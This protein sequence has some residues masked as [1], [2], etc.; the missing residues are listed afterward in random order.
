MK[1]FQRRSV[2]SL[3]HKRLTNFLLRRALRHFTVHVYHLFIHGNKIPVLVLFQVGG[4]I[5]INNVTIIKITNIYS[6]GDVEI[7]ISPSVLQSLKIKHNKTVRYYN[8]TGFFILYV[9]SFYNNIH[10]GMTI[11]EFNLCYDC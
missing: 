9:S 7:V 6:T 5:Q 1:I 4:L 2:S 11:A 8:S 10:I 3:V